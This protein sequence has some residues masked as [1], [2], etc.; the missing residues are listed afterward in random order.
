[1]TAET[2]TESGEGRVLTDFAAAFPQLDFTAPD[3]EYLRSVATALV[4]FGELVGTAVTEISAEQA[5]VTI[6]AGES[7]TNHMGTVHA[8][9][10]F[11]AADI[12]GALAFIGAAAPRLYTIER[13]VLRAATVTYRRP[14]LGAIRAVAHI[15]ERELRSVLTAD[16]G[17]R[18]DITAKAVVLD[19]AGVVTAK[20][21]FDYVCDVVAATPGNSR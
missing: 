21:V 14:A 1:M 13:L 18:H 3:Y 5:V 19:D 11:T 8:G 10:Q 16:D 20:L 9:A 17:G 2:A 7:V 15:D 12:A 6:A 4:P